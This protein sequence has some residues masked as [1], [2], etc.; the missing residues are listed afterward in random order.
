MAVTQ[1]SVFLENRPGQ[2]A[3]I[4]GV[5]FR[6]GVNLRA[7]NIAET[8]D[9]GVL[10]LIADNSELACRVLAESGFIYSVGKVAAVTVPDEPG[11]LFRILNLLAEAGVDV[12]YMYSIF[13]G[14][15]GKAYMVMKMDEEKA[16]A[17]LKASG[18]P[19]ANAEDIGLH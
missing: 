7:L 11:G 19:P 5:L 8:A 13:G 3:E 18:F 12:E 1:I 16:R 14:R 9:Y 2:L 4:T 6:E 15:D 10:R 17:V